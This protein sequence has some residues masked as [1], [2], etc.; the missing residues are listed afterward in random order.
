MAGLS[1]LFRG[2][3]PAKR[4]CL[5]SVR[6]MACEGR[7]GLEPVGLD[8]EGP[9]LGGRVVPVLAGGW[10]VMREYKWMGVRRG[11][12]RV[13]KKIGVG[14]VILNTYTHLLGDVCCG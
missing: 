9:E 6:A 13:G 14:W 8:L 12:R 5:A 1:T 7:L 4:G 10:L 2:S 3:P 11:A